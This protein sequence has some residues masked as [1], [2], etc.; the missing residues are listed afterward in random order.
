M[1]FKD[2]LKGLGNY[3]KSYRTF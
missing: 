1:D 3:E 2:T